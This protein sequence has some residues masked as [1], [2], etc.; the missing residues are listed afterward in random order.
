MPE[1][2]QERRLGVACCRVEQLAVIPVA[3]HVPKRVVIY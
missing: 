1:V 3:V 2:T